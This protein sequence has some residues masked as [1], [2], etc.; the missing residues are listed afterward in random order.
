MHLFASSS[1]YKDSVWG[2]FLES[3]RKDLNKLLEQ[4]I[5]NIVLLWNA[6][7]AL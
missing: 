4:V 2:A 6:T 5:L 1:S 3:A 7:A